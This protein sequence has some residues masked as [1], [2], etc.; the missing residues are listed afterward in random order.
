M[1]ALRLA[2]VASVLSASVVA[3]QTDAPTPAALASVALPSDLDRVLRDYER[4]WQAHDSQALSDLFAED[5]FVLGNTLPPVR[6]RAAVR[7]AYSGAGGPLS[8][9]ALAWS[10]AGGIGYIIGG[11][12]PAPGVADSGKFVLTLKH[13][14]EGRWLIM[15][16]MD[17]PNQPRP[18]QPCPNAAG[19]PSSPSPPQ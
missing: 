19:T 13:S 11:F 3:Q 6:G 7:A 14:G 15:S 2:L 16:D 5:G 17:N 18:R 1:K 10:T 9:R 8:L 12:G 4:A